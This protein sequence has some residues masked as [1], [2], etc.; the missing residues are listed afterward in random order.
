MMEIFYFLLIIAL[1]IYSVIGQ[2]NQMIAGQS[3]CEADSSYRLY[4]AKTDYSF[5]GDYLNYK[6]YQ[7]PRMSN[8]IS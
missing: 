1:A 7:V 5:V 3:S 2:S 8:I 4:S 6:D